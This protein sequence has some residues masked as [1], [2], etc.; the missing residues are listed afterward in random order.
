MR[1]AVLHYDKDQDY[2][3]ING[4]DGK[5]YFFVSNDLTQGA[6]LVSGTLVEFQP[7]DGTAHNIVAVTPTAPSSSAGQPQQPRRSAESGPASST[8]LGAYFWR[9]IIADYSN[10][11]GRA[12][13]KEFWAF[14]LCFNLVLVALLGFGILVN[15]AVN[16]FGINAGKTSIGFL[17]AAVFVLAFGLPWTALTVR[18]LHDVGLS[19]WFVL[20]G[21]IPAIGAV[22]LLVLGLAP[23][24]LGE[25]PWGRMPAG[26][27]V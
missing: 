17:P 22:A 21:Y 19:G 24:Q 14:C 7:D 13:R 1:G 15:L 26:V 3:Y 6:A 12:R 23:S 18:R 4:V 2:G 8:G 10:F 5:R 11:S 9:A 20:L 16:G 25:N 27:R